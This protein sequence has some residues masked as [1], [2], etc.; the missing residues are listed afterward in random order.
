[1]PIKKM[2]QNNYNFFAL[3]VKQGNA[4]SVIN[5]TVVVS[6]T[7]TIAATTTITTTTSTYAFC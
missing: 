4:H 3:H 1:M 2:C 5:I 6:V 7:S